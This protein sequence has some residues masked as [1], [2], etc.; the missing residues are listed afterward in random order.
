MRPRA[1]LAASLAA[2]FL[3]LGV[4][5]ETA[6]AASLRYFGYFAARLTPTDG[7]HL[8]EVTSR[9]NLNWVQFSDFDK[10][11]V[12]VLDHCSVGGCIV[13]AA[14][15]FFKGCDVANG[16]C[17]LYPDYAARW[18]R[19]AS[20]V[21][22]RIDK[23]AAFF[24][25]D[26]PQVYGASAAEVETAARTI[27]ATYPTIPVMMNEAGPQLSATYQVPPSVD[28]VGFD[29]YCQPF[30]TVEKTLA[31]L[32]SLTTAN[33]SLFLF[34]EAA[35]LAVCNGAAGHATDAE[36][37]KLQYSYY[38]LALKNPRVIGLLNYGFWTDRTPAQ[39]PQ[40]V[41]A[42]QNIWA[43]IVAANQPPPPAPPPGP[44]PPP[45]PTPKPERKA[46]IAG[47]KARIDSRGRIA[48]SL[49]CPAGN[50]GNC[51][52]RLKLTQPAANRRRLVGARKFDLPA[53]SSATL[54]VRAKERWRPKLLR[55][56]QHG[57]SV[58]LRATTDSGARRTI[59]L[60]RQHR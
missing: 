23:V 7:D 32:S 15:E 45:A 30:S 17:D 28:W 50:S 58:R 34:P 27:A 38:N 4:G 48:L 8:P 26:E 37:A 19:L 29:W 14:N 12:E 31:L 35:P 57:E 59:E 60:M 5:F 39:L 33:Q 43:A 6:S 18:Q 24:V 2:A 9:T 10:T 51:S 36:I 20:L 46:R 40:T 55:Q 1:F 47:Q 16:P 42:H 25:K 53:G 54:V 49:R 3:T 11:R 41:A 13:S 52:G 56:T 44:A 21:A 22:P